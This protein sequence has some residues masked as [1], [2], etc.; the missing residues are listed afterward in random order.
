MSNQLTIRQTTERDISSL[1]L[2]EQAAWSG[3][4]PRDF[5]FTK[6][7]FSSH[8][9]LF[10]EGQFVAELDGR[11]V[12]YLTLQRLTASLETLSQVVK[13]WL[14]TTGNGFITTHDPNGNV[15]FG[16]SMGALPEQLGA[17]IQLVDRGIELMMEL[18]CDF[19]FLVGRMPGYDEHAND[20]SPKDYVNA[21]NDEGKP[22]DPQIRMYTGEG[23]EIGGLVPN[24]I[25]DPRSHNFGVLLIIDNPNK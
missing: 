8:L 21:T 24:Y 3:E 7:H 4:V 10:P 6:V 23:L 13:S 12:A 22:L 5:L 18:G 20:M 16:V 9:K 11:V 1:C 19:G 25:R 15:M 2:V 17:G 14:E